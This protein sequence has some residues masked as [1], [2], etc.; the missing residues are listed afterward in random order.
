MPRHT[1]CHRRDDA[2]GYD[3]PSASAE[4]NPNLGSHY[5]YASVVFVV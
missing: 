1:W 5:Q 2:E 4:T 3:V